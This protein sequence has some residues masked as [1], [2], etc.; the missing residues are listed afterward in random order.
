MNP[1]V[2][3]T[4]RVARI[5]CILLL[6]YA[7]AQPYEAADPAD[8]GSLLSPMGAIAYLRLLLG[9]TGVPLLSLISGYLLAR[10]L[11]TRP[12]IAE[13]SNKFFS[14]IVPLVLWNLIY[15]GKEYAESSFITL[16]ALLEWPDA[17]LALTTH[18]AMVP[19]Y[20][21]R[22][23][24]VCFL[25]SPALMYLARKL[26][27][28]TVA[29]LLINA[30]LNIDDVL[31]IN[32][33]IPLFYFAGCVLM[34][35]CVPIPTH[36]THPMP[37][38]P[39]WTAG[40]AMVLLSAAPFY[41]PGEWGIS[42]VDSVPFAAVDIA[43]RAA[44]CVVFWAVASR[45]LH[46]RAGDVLL[47]YE[48]VAFFLFCAHGMAAGLWWMALGHMGYADVTPVFLGYF[49]LSPLLA[50]VGCVAAVWS[51]RQATPRFLSLLMGGRS[52]N[53]HQMNNMIH[54]LRRSH[55]ELRHG[56]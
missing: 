49:A 55:L 7:H 53:P 38:G 39:V 26:P 8:P 13:F 6:V 5:L 45:L 25:I 42:D 22:D 3:D 51:I 33:A 10:T 34:V 23:A 35:R 21:L 9:H 12:W 30:L 28:V 46:S 37:R 54:A 43:L 48:P 15:I 31:F 50:L 19:L 27:G 40:L 1:E 41:R 44:G 20:F 36:P 18:P 4:I 14:L 24:F 2:S 11:S 17:V 16:P 56:A 29:A 47:R 32:S 52:P